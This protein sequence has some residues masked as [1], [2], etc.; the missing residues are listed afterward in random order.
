[1]LEADIPENAP[2]RFFSIDTIPHFEFLNKEK[3]DTSDTRT[4][5]VLKQIIRITSFDSGHWVIPSFDLQ[6]NGVTDTLPVD[7]GYSEPFDRTQ[8]YHDVKDIMEVKPKEKEEQKTWWYYAVG[9]GLILLLILWLLLRKKKK[10]VVQEI[11]RPADPY[12]DAMQKL[13]QL[14]RD[15]RD[16]K[17][18]Y[19]SLTDIFRVYILAKKGIHSLQKTTDDLVVQLRDVGLLKAGFDRLSQALRL[20]DFVK[21]AKYIPSENDDRESLEAIRSSIEEIERMNTVVP[22]TGSQQQ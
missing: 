8:P 13:S 20:S 16:A 6:E 15:K 11:S 12:K 3:I 1:M 14:E 7:V 21:F 17:Y 9:A 10:P 5:T 2:I 22:A 18:Y 4:G 19:S